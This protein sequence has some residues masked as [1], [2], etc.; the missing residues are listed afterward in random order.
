MEHCLMLNSAEVDNEWMVLNQALVIITG[1]K[2][3]I[4]SYLCLLASYMST[5]M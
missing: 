2:L 1:M 3:Q 4:T 5:D